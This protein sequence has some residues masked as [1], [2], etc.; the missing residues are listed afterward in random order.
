MT[1]K[2]EPN[3]FDLPDEEKTRNKNALITLWVLAPMSVVT[4]GVTL[5]ALIV[6]GLSTTF[7]IMGALFLVLLAMAIVAF[8]FNKKRA[9]FT[10][11]TPSY[12]IELEFQSPK[13]YVPPE[14]F[15]QTIVV[16]SLEAFKP[17]HD[18]SDE[19]MTKNI[20]FVVKD[21]KPSHW[22]FGERHGM[23]WP[24]AGL[25]EVWGPEVLSAGTAGYELLLH[26]CH[27]LYPGRSEAED[28]AWMQEKGIL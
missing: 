20:K 13:Y 9:N 18:Y 10:F 24:K 11:K 7:W 15:E 26:F 5:Y 6:T 17:F 3:T 16:P 14:I 19:E 25:S 2:I 12:G 22:A 4:L 28:L 1:K 8:F 21:R 23:T 27:R